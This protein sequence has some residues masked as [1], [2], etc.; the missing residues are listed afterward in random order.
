LQTSEAVLEI[1]GMPK[2]DG[3]A[4]TAEFVGDLKIGR[5]IFIC[6]SQDQPTPEDQSLRR[7]MSSDQNM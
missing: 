1:A 4:S 2:S 6:E 5:L 3:V 7:G